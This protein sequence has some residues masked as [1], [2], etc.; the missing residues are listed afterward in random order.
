[1]KLG[2]YLNIFLMPLLISAQQ[3]N[4]EKDF[5]FVKGFSDTIYLVKDEYLEDSYLTFKDKES[6]YA[7][8]ENQNFNKTGEIIN[9]YMISIQ[10]IK[11]FYISVDDVSEADYHSFCKATGKPL[12]EPLT[13]DDMEEYCEYLSGLWSIPVRL[14]AYA[15]WPYGPGFRLVITKSDL[16]KKLIFDKLNG[17]MK[18]A[19][20]MD[21]PVHFTY[22]GVE[23]GDKSIKWEDVRDMRVDRQKQ[24]VIIKGT[25]EAI[26][27]HYT[28]EQY[29]PVASVHVNF[30]AFLEKL[31]NE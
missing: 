13:S 16:D 26:T 2:I 30:L 20:G 19:Y 22:N 6:L 24:K 25:Q 3:F 12:S 18:E 1:M 27:F 28:E 23:S 8:F 5:E 14:P 4:I 21:P 17:Y 10:E 15:E 9:E 7:H 11:D 31:N 29:T